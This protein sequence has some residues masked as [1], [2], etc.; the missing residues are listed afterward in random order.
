MSDPQGLKIP[1]AIV[2]V[3]AVLFSALLWRSYPGVKPQMADV[4]APVVVEIKGDV[5]A[6]GTYFLD[7]ERATISDALSAAGRQCISGDFSNR[8]ESGQSLR[9]ADADGPP[10][11][12][13]GRMPASARLT[14]GLKLDLNSSS[15][16]DLML[17]PQMR[18]DIVAA[19]V[20][21]RREKPWGKVA[22]L[23]E[24]NGIGPKTVHKF[25]EF[26]EVPPN[27]TK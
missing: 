2:L 24:V 12:V 17:V 10:L 25:E 16:E 1:A 23:I 9:V 22:D 5:P 20:E 27:V 18:Q 7:R 3:S 26:L 6:P 14:I 11:V 15:G 21:R 8:L 4:Q 13:I 19:I